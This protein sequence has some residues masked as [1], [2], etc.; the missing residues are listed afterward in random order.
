MTDSANSPRASRLGDPA[1][2]S[3]QEARHGLVVRPQS[4]ADGWSAQC[5][6]GW[7]SFASFY[8]Y[9]T[10]DQL[11]AELQRRYDAHMV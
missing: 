5:L 6:C 7:H 4:I 2:Q 11:L 10:R 3:G 1:G 8:E 9:D